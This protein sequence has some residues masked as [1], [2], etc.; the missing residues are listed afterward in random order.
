MRDLRR[1][2]LDL[3]DITARLRA[4][5]QGLRE[6]IDPPWEAQ[7]L[8]DIDPSAAHV[9]SLPSRG[10]ISALVGAYAG[11]NGDDH[12]EESMD[13]VWGS[14]PK[15]WFGCAGSERRWTRPM[16][17]ED[18][19]EHVGGMILIIKRSGEVPEDM[20]WHINREG[21]ARALVE[22]ICRGWLLEDGHALLALHLVGAR[23]VASFIRELVAARRWP[24]ARS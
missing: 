15:L 11:A 8:A 7:A 20:R 3:E 16:H 19:R 24:E 17:G 21:G 10:S 12:W 22:A 2:E 9:M 4:V 18:L 6:G 23:K 5:A 1:A 14:P 13:A